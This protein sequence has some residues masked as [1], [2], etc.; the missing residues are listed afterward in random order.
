MKESDVGTDLHGDK[1]V[2]VL[3][4]PCMIYVF[5]VHI[6]RIYKTSIRGGNHTPSCINTSIAKRVNILR[7]FLRDNATSH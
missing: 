5:D 2:L 1:G 3:W 6:V 7:L 4:D